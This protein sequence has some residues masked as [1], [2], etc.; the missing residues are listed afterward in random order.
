MIL[1]CG[2]RY[3][4]EI[5]IVSKS[6]KLQSLKTALYLLRTCNFANLENKISIFTK[7]HILQGYLSRFDRLYDFSLR[8]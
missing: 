4:L 5:V 2:V 8:Q 1:H 3:K 7:K 6:A